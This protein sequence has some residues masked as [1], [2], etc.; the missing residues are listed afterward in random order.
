MHRAALDQTE[1]GLPQN[2]PIVFIIEGSARG[3]PGDV[4]AGESSGSVLKVSN[5]N[6]KED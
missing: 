5:A 4:G 2:F 1:S 3:L 6:M